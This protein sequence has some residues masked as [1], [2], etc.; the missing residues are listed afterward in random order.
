[1]SGDLTDIEI[2][3]KLIVNGLTM[4]VFGV[5]MCFGNIWSHPP[6]RTAR[7]LI[8]NCVIIKSTHG[9]YIFS[10]PISSM[11]NRTLLD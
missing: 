11:V 2:D 9:I 7:S 8:Y 6:G 5:G 1:M 3:S 10:L 4:F